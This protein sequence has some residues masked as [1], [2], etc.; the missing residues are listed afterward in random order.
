MTRTQGTRHGVLAAALLAQAALH[1]W[2][3]AEHS[4]TFDEP[5]YIAAGMAYATTGQ[6]TQAF[7]HPPL[8][9]RIAG[10]AALAAGG[11]PAGAEHDLHGIDTLY[12]SNADRATRILRAARW[13]TAFGTLALTVVVSLA[14]RRV[15][16]DAAGMLAAGLMAVEPNLLAHGSLATT[17]LWLALFITLFTIE[18][19]A[20]MS[21]A[22]IGRFRVRA[23]IWAGLALSSKFSALGFLPAT[24]FGVWL[25]LGRT[26]GWGRHLRRFA[27]AGPR[28]AAYAALTVG[29]V[30][31]VHLRIFA[32]GF[33]RTGLLSWFPVTLSGEMNYYLPWGLK[34]AARYASEGAPAY[35]HG[36]MRAGMIPA[37]FPA[38]LLLKMP[39]AVFA[40]AGL[41]VGLGGVRGPRGAM[42]LAALAMLASVLA[43]RIHIGIRHVLPV[44]PLVILV[45]A[46]VLDAGL[47]RRRLRSGLAILGLL[48]ASTST[49]RCAPHFLAHFNEISG[50]PAGGWRWLSDSSIDWGQDLPSMKRW[51]DANGVK[52]IPLYY[53][54]PADP[55]FYGI[56]GSRPLPDHP[57]PVSGLVAISVSWLN[58]TTTGALDRF[59]WVRSLTPIA[60]PGWSLHVYDVKELTNPSRPS[61]SRRR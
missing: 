21:G 39:L 44:V 37:Y 15:W 29:A 38:T 24:A 59:G 61:S 35:F 3:I 42:T 7:I 18:L 51:M 43:S 28:L 17:D 23:G 52:E 49:F 25:G 60:T 26:E 16:G 32:P 58:G 36:V 11:D 6:D 50:G 2:F 47:P 33:G 45:A 55:A 1:G 9:K 31:S 57:T 19:P 13:A 27:S 54:G 8:A 20:I 41:A 4:A 56:N 5:A 10:F 46:S 40:L 12:N 34:W 48:W 53:F 22:A 14:A 30:Y